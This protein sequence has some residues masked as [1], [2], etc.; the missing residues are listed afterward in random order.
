VLGNGDHDWFEARFGAVLKITPM[1]VAFSK[2]RHWSTGADS[3][4]RTVQFSCTY[5][6]CCLGAIAHKVPFF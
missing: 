3:S 6:P 2:R 4:G 1:A 5:S